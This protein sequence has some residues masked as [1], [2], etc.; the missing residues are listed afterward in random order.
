MAI[1]YKKSPFKQAGVTA[2]SFTANPD[3][4]R[5][6][7]GYVFIL[8]AESISFGAVTQM[9][10]AQSTKESRGKR[11]CL[12]SKVSGVSVEGF[13][14]SFVRKPIRFDRHKLRQHWGIAVLVLALAHQGGD[15][16]NSPRV[17]V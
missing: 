14:G 4:R 11:G 12:P 10:T 7:T 16:Q 9:L 8:G 2:S 1:T 3:S 13:R 5:S 15:D 17:N 6:T